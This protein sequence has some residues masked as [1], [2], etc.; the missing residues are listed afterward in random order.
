MNRT[1]IAAIPTETGGMRHDI[2]VH[3]GK[4]GEPLV[5]L[6][7]AG[8]AMLISQDADGHVSTET[9]ALIDAVEAIEA[10]IAKLKADGYVEHSRLCQEAVRDAKVVA[11]VP[12]DAFGR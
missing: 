2:P 3:A 8:V 11:L 10:M 9:M 1:T 12:H 7:N 5:V 6:V 4:P